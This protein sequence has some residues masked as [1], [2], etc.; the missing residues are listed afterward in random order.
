MPVGF[1]ILNLPEAKIEDS[2]IPND[3]SVWSSKKVEEQINSSSTVL[4]TQINA[5]V[6]QEQ[7]NANADVTN[8][9]T[10]TTVGHIPLYDTQNGKSLK[11][12]GVSLANITATNANLQNQINA[13]V[14]QEQNNANADVTNTDTTVISDDIPVY[15]GTTGKSLKSS[16][17]SFANLTATNTNL[18][19]Q[20]NQIIIT[21]Q[22]NADAD[23]TNSDATV[24]VGDIPLYD[25]TTGKVLKSSGLSLAD[26]SQGQ[27]NTTI[28][29]VVNN[30]IVKYS[31]TSGDSIQQTGVTIDAS[32]NIS[33]PGTYNGFDLNN[34]NS[35]INQNNINSQNADTNLQT[36]IDQIII[37][38]Q[39][40]S[41][42]DVTNSDATVISNNIPVYDGTTGK[43]LKS[44]GVTISSVNNMT[45]P[46]LINGHDINVMNST[47]SQNDAHAQN[48]LNP[49]KTTLQQTLNVPGQEYNLLPGDL[50][51]IN[52]SAPTQ[53][54]KL[55]IGNQGEE[56]E[57]NNGNLFWSDKT[58]NH[59][60][61]TFN[62]HKVTIQ[63]TLR[64]SNLHAN[65]GDLIVGLGGNDVTLFPTA[66]DSI[67][68]TNNIGIQEYLPKTSFSSFVGA[69]FFKKSGNSIIG[70]PLA[71]IKILRIN[72]DFASSPNAY[73]ITT[74]VNSRMSSR[75][76]V[77][78]LMITKST[79]G[80]FIAYDNN[81]HS[82]EVTRNDQFSNAGAYDYEVLND[83]IYDWSVLITTLGDG[84]VI[85]QLF[86]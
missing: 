45:I 47:I 26:L 39:N 12:S 41:A 68:A 69:N 9:D 13:I 86:P 71:T 74:V 78:E 30:S 32:N 33:T 27:V 7:S 23:V 79:S 52:T 31:G 36:Q 3:V 72:L 84:P 1:S 4:Q 61:N 56:L 62:P 38:E 18:Q 15:D 24:T 75:F 14:I 20:I 80:Y 22:N 64:E 82:P 85:E 65:R 28:K 49:H 51:T 54:T 35:T 6:I 19:N 17:V 55:P 2:E 43:V 66:N 25:N 57:V 44:T 29:P 10:S 37:T 59:L 48:I 76:M 81:F 58:K 67:L 40:N 83:E 11:S 34:L 46:G 16:G 50:L 21:E 73:K 8:T 77:N 53:I 70:I 42:N 5:I 60:L 63:D